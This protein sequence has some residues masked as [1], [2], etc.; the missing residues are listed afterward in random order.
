ML[1][2]EKPY[3][4]AVFVEKP[5]SLKMPMTASHVTANASKTEKLPR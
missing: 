2:A 4:Y 5:L 1:T 3:K